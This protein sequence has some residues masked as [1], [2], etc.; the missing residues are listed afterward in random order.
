MKSAIFSVLIT[1]FNNADEIDKTWESIWAQD[2]PKENIWIYIVDFGSSDGT[3]EKILSYDRYHTAVFQIPDVYSERV[4]ESRA[5]SLVSTQMPP[6][7]VLRLV[8]LKP[9]DIL[10]QSCFSVCAETLGRY[11]AQGLS[12]MV[13]EADTMDLNGEIT[14]HPYIAEHEM[15]LRPVENFNLLLGEF[16]NH[17]VGYIGGEISTRYSEHIGHERCFWNKAAYSVNFQTK[18]I[19]VP[20]TLLCLKERAYCDEMDEL[21]TRWLH[22]INFQRGVESMTGTAM[23]IDSLK[24]KRNLA[25]YALW[26]LSR[27]GTEL[28]Q[29]E[30]E[31]MLLTAAIID[32]EIKRERIYAELSSGEKREMTADYQ[33]YFAKVCREGQKSIAEAIKAGALMVAVPPETAPCGHRE[34]G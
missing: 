29:K 31:D 2:Y 11:M 12:L 3:Y 20:Q 7:K 28:S 14:S 5:I 18:L 13:C 21:L 16:P 17:Y 33:R 15:L 19:Y 10:Y 25:N 24:I 9:G 22:V 6:G 27:H 34:R 8:S 26:R 1:T 32:P 30:R 4:R 23:E